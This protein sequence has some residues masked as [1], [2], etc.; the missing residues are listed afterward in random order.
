MAFQTREKVKKT[1]VKNRY[2]TVI[3]TVAQLN[4]CRISLL[5]V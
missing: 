4:T 1:T 3:V 5:H 2:L